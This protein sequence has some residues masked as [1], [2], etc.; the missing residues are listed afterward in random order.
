ME[1]LIRLQNEKKLPKNFVIDKRALDDS[2]R[3]V[4]VLRFLTEF[5][6]RQSFMDQYSD[7]VQIGLALESEG[8]NRYYP[9]VLIDNKYVD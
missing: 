4:D 8:I 2:D 6:L 3:I 5:A 9:Q 1:I 7:L